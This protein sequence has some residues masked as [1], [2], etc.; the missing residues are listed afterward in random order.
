MEC[1][2]L[3]DALDDEQDSKSELQRLISKANAEAAQWRAR[4]EGTLLL[5]FRG[6][7]PCHKW[8]ISTHPS[9][10]EGMSRSEEVE[11]ARRKLAVK[12][13]EVQEQ[14]DQA[15]MRVASEEKKRHKLQQELEDAQVDAERANSLANSLEKKQK[16]FDKVID[17]W[18]LKADALSQELEAAQRDTRNVRIK[19]QPF[20]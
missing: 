19:P 12:M 16:Q 6:F 15:N 13:Q 2:Q 10:G 7:K 8:Q 17:E 20:I 1:Q 3:R 18:R 11:E 14:V 9:L 4:Y 5:M